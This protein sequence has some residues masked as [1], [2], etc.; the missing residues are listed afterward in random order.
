MSVKQIKSLVQFSRGTN[1]VWGALTTPIP[2]GVATFSIDDGTF[3]IGDGINTYPNLPTLFTFADLIAAQGGVSALFTA[4][5]LASNGYIVIISFDAVSG[6][7]KYAISTTTLASLLA[8]LTSL[9]SANTAQDAAI[10]QLLAIGLSIDVSINTGTNGNIITIQNGRY[11]DSGQNLATIQA[12]INSG[13]NYIPGS[14]LLDPVFYSDVNK[15]KVIDKLKMYDNN[16]YY[17]DVIGFNNN[18]ALPVFALTAANTNITVTKIAGSLFSIRLNGVTSTNVADTPIVLIVSVDDGTGKATAKKAVAALVLR[19]RILVS[20]YGGAQPDGFGGVAID[21]SGNIIAV[22]FTYSENT[23]GNTIY[24][25]ALVVKFDS[26]LNIL[27]K[28]RYGL[29]LGFESF[30]KVAVDS[31]NNIIVVGLTTSEPIGNYDALVIKL[32]TNLNILIKKRY[33]AQTATGAGDWFTSVAVDAGNNI[34]CAGY[35]VSEGQ[36]GTTYGDC[37]VVKFD[38]NLNILARKIYGGA[39]EDLFYGVTTDSAGN[40]ICVGCT[41]SE[42]TQ[43][44]GYYSALIIKFD[45]FLNIVYRKLYNATSGTY[46]EFTGVVCDSSN[47]I[48]VCGWSNTE[49]TSGIDT[50]VMKFDSNLNIITRKRYGGTGNDRF[51]NIAADINNNITCVG[52]TTSEGLGGTDYGDALIVKFDTNLSIISKKKYGGNSDDQFC[53]VVV[54][55]FGNTYCVGS[56]QSN[57]IYDAIIVKLPTIIPTGTFIGPILSGLTMSDITTFVLADSTLVLTNSALTLA[58]SNLALNN[59]TGTITNSFLYQTID[60]LN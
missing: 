24:H 43:T 21:N 58:N 5:V 2:D 38:S 46:T 55:S 49:G 4:P 42:G 7:T 15:T 51:L 48:C 50:L 52:F 28:K 33:G 54:D 47:S 3:K 17:V 44:A 10:A 23:D 16:T 29:S 36:G 59:S 19:S 40:I 57:S 26:N 20:L 9:D 8:S 30:S 34:I 1:L 35:T 45:A 53:G 56:I 12:T 37:L 32:D 13:V 60:T 41:A 31:N 11:S 14:H 39:T 18:V 22:G 6:K 27:I 25:D